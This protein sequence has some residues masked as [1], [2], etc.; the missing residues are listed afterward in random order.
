MNDKIGHRFSSTGCPRLECVLLTL[1]YV[2]F[3]NVAPSIEGAFQSL[4]S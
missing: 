3:N 2:S 4:Y 1:P